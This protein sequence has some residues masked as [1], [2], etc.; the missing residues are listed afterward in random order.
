MLGFE[1]GFDLLTDEQILQIATDIE[2]NG[3]KTLT[4]KNKAIVIIAKASNEKFECVKSSTY[5]TNLV[6]YVEEKNSI[7][8]GIDTAFKPVERPLSLLGIVNL[9]DEAK[10]TLL[11][12]YHNQANMY[13]I[14]VSEDLTDISIR[15]LF[16][17]EKDSWVMLERALKLA[18]L[19]A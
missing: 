15:Q 1:Q 18:K 19:I 5:T 16:D 7:Y 12:I 13:F 8:I 2:L 4:F 17:I 3:S 10:D 11:K 9:S 6:Q 14:S